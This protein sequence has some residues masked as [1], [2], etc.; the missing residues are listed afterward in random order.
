MA[1]P[2]PV[3]ERERKYEIAAGSGV[4][5]LVGVGGVATQSDPVEH[6]LD[7]SYYDTQ[8]YRLARGGL[9]LRRRVGGPD[10]GWHLKL[11]VS[12]DERQEIRLPLGGD[13]HKVPGRLRR[14]VRA[15]T[16]GEKLVP[17]AH[18]R[19]DRFAH[20]LADAGGRTIATLTDDH[21]TGEAGGAT[22]RLDEW[23]ELELELEP[24]TEPGRLGEFD[25]A[26]TGA[27]VTAAAWPSK[28]RRLLGDRLPAPPRPRKKP[29]A[30][31]VVLAS[32][33]EHYGRL[34]RADVGVRLDVD[35]SVHQMRVAIRKLR[36]TLRTFG[37]VI[38]KEAT[39]PLAAELKWL[40]GQLAPARDTE[41][42]EERLRE[43]LDDVPSELVFGPVRQFLTRYFAREAE[44]GRTRA[45]SALTGKRY[46]ELL[47][48][49]DAVLE[50]PPLTAQARKPAKAGLRKPLRK[51]AK[52]LSRAEAAAR[53]LTGNELGLALHDVRKKA[54]QARYATDTVKPVYGKKLGKW[55]KNVKAVQ[56]TLGAHQDTVVGREVLHHLAIAGHG[57]GQN[58]F[59]FGVLHAQD[60]G[61]AAELRG[62]FAK[63]WRRLRKGGR[64]GWLG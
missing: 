60:A 58:T 26:L 14:L 34:R 55:R 15:Y 30:G 40:G 38:D 9:T 42:T 48:A 47:R 57:E 31:D 29:S 7:A 50:D 6:V 41:V 53:G 24:E 35:D 51:A 4:P 56:Q 12:A 45:M 63:Q 13:P 43:Q 59:A 37:S 46:V 5:R 25:R 36:S 39:A 17:V 33:R 61:R 16:L 3:P 54:K 1:A 32:L 18:L 64:P 28:L 49:L 52:K 10:A 11:P 27:G 8:S 23:R 21:V 62:T 22:A 20:R 44:E 19:T 2:A